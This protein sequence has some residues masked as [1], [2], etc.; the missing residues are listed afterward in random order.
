MTPLPQVGS[1]R[2][3]AAVNNFGFAGGNMTMILKEALI[4]NTTDAYPPLTDIIAVTAETKG[5]LTGHLKCFTAHLDAHPD[6]PLA[7][8][9]YTTTARRQQ[10]RYRVAI[11]IF[12]DHL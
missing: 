3:L 9:S 6:I 8:L 2:R 10:H 4:R 11:T 1:K 12:E 5:S 7:N